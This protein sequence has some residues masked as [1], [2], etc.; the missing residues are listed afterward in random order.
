MNGKSK[1]PGAIDR[2]VADK[3]AVGLMQRIAVIQLRQDTGGGRRPIKVEH[4]LDAA[5]ATNVLHDRAP[6]FL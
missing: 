4:G 1:G 6:T 3:N 2:G 5:E